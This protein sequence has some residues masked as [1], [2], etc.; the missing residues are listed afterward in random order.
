MVSWYFRP[1]N[2]ILIRQTENVQVARQVRFTNL[3]EIVKMEKILKAYIYE[4]IE[5]EKAGL[6][7]GDPFRKV[8]LKKTKE[9]NM[10]EEFQKKLD[11][12]KALKTTFDKLTPGKQ[13]GYIFYFSQTKQFRTREARVEKYMKQILNGKELDD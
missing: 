13:R 12:N 2:G 3:Q 10:P 9:F 7:Q 4:A 5:I 8:K 6:S 11:K 1:T